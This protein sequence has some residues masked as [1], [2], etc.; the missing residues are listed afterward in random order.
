M[1]K[2]KKHDIV[3]IIGILAF[4]IVGILSY[5]YS[6][7][8]IGE[9]T[10][11]PMEDSYVDFIDCGQGDSALIS[12]EGESVL[13]D[14]STSDESESVVSHLKKRGISKIGVLILTHPHEDH[15]GGAEAV[16]EQFEVEKIIMKRPTKGTEPTSA[17]YISLLKKIKEKD[18]EVVNATPD[19]KFSCG[20]WE[21]SVLGPIEEYEDLND[22]S[23]VLHGFYGKTSILF[24][25]DQ[26]KKAEKDLLD[27][28]GGQLRSTIYAVSHHGS[29]SS[30]CDE[31]LDAVRPQYAVISCGDE[32]SY[33]HPHKETLERLEERG[34]AV[35]R[36]DIDGTVTFI[37]DG[38][39]I[40]HKE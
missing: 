36:T 12:S 9:Q 34:I 31:I 15:I 7:G 2:R 35:F 18:V 14:T 21:F 39:T 29:R 23:I 26:E 16:L 40:E 22:Q 19:V 25:G 13:V 10:L 38:V 17:V 6:N 20:H 11:E 24:K 30:S 4:V 3:K 37:T 28:Y 32:N 8:I 1:A 33:G 5:L 27:R